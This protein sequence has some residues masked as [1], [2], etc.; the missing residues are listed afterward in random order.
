LISNGRGNY[1]AQTG[2]VQEF[3]EKRETEN[4]MEWETELYNEGENF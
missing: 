4:R 3:L 1:Y 2:S